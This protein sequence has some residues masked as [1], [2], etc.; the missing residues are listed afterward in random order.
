MG[1]FF[2]ALVFTFFAVWALSKPL[3]FTIEDIRHGL[4][5]II[6]MLQTK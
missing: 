6:A 4:K 2:K 5:I 1:S 3:D